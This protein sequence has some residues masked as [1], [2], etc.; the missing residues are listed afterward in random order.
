MSK[1][2]LI[3]ENKSPRI[4]CVFYEVDCGQVRIAPV[5]NSNA[6][7]EFEF[8]VSNK[9]MEKE[10]VEKSANAKFVGLAKSAVL[11]NTSGSCSSFCFVREVNELGRGDFVKIGPLPAEKP[12]PKASS[13]CL[14]DTKTHEQEKA[15]MEAKKAEI[16]SNASPLVG[17]A[18][19]GE[20]A[21]ISAY[22]RPAIVITERVGEAESTLEFTAAADYKVWKELQ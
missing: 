3:S 11:A 8:F 1:E 14:S 21:Y 2:V 12:V 15:I 6:D 7:A 4:D 5:N 20:S 17:G 9:D 19:G 16:R 13:E 10:D 22:H 18:C